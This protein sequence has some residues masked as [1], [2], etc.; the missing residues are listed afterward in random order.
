VHWAS[1]SDRYS[2]TAGVDNL[3]DE[4]YRAFGDYQPGFGMDQEVFDRGVQWYLMA[5][6]SYK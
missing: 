2:I 5:S 1:P 4:E 6:F 3:T